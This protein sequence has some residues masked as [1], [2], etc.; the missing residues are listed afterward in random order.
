[1]GKRTDRRSVMKKYVGIPYKHNGRPPDKELD[2][3]GFIVYY[4][5]NEYGV[6]LPNYRY[7]D[8]TEKS[9]ASFEIVNTDLF[10]ITENVNIKDVKKDDILLFNCAGQPMHVG[11]AID[12]NMM[13][14]CDRKVGSIIE[15]FRSRLWE[16]RLYKAARLNLENFN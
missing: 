6:T 10:K 8:P 4:F 15:S 13:I 11:L 14:H 16:K 2:C 3:W 5:K 1:M 7:I 12:N 9:V